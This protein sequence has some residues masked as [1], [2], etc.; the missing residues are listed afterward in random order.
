MEYSLEYTFRKPEAGAASVAELVNSDKAVLSREGSHHLG[1][2]GW[3][4]Y[5]DF[6]CRTVERQWLNNKPYVSCIPAGLWK[7]K[8]DMY[9]GG[10]GVGGKG[11][12]PAYELIAV[13]KRSEIKIHIANIYSDVYGCIGIGDDI[14]VSKGTWGVLNSTK[15][16]EKW[17]EVTGGEEELWLDIIWKKF[18]KGGYRWQV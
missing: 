5:K 17:M 9:W 6:K 16:Y 1:T 11:D 10:D 4:E 12:Y 13:P 14:G 3:L 15:T 18:E 2:F 8:L 7:M